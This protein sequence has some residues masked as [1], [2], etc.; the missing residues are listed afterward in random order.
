MIKV[1]T[2]ELEKYLSNASLPVEIRAMV[3]QAVKMVLF[4]NNSLDNVIKTFLFD[5]NLIEEVDGGFVAV[6]TK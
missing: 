4:E 2:K 5:L 3:D 6:K 1:K